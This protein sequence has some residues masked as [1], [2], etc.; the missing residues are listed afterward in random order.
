VQA[1]FHLDYYH[2]HIL[3]YSDFTIQANLMNNIESAQKLE[4]QIMSVMNTAVEGNY[5]HTM[6]HQLTQSDSRR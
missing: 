4:D 1:F 5:S 6:F 3:E 2:L